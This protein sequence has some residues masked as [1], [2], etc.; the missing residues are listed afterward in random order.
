MEQEGPTHAHLEQL[1][2]EFDRREQEEDMISILNS[3]H[4]K[5]AIAQ[6][7]HY[8]TQESGASQFHK[9]NYLNK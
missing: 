5:T 9:K 7:S 4:H 8:L 3:A 2:K 1:E 6:A